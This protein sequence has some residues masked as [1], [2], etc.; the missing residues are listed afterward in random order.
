MIR[1]DGFIKIWER[2][3]YHFKKTWLVSIF[4]IVLEPLMYL[5]AI[6]Y[7][8]GSYVN[9]MEGQSFLEFYFP[10]L[11]AST[12]MMVAF[13]EGTYAN[14]SKL[15]YQKLYATIIL[16]PIGPEE[17]IVGELFWSSTKSFL[18]VLGVTLIASFFGLV[19][20][21]RIG[22][23]FLIL[24]LSSWLFSSFA[25]L[26]VSYA[27]NYDSFIFATSGF[28][29]PMSLI[30]GT[31]F[32]IDSLPI[33]L[34]ILSY[35]LPLAHSVRATRLILT[36]LWDYSI[37]IHIGYLL[38]VGYILTKVSIRRISRRLYN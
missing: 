13:F 21:A 34:K 20:F 23:A 32:P 35:I 18:S 11:L 38:L 24:F 31:Y 3:F 22:P 17:I 26:I 9:S 4:W 10:G 2:N 14:Y 16:A 7:G 5:G 27:R 19:D 6:G 8:L 30:S 12:A 29:I 33:G 36:G 37:L 25:M 15:T 1:S 28:I